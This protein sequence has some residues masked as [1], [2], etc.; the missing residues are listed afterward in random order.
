MAAIDKQRQQPDSDLLDDCRSLCSS[1]AERLGVS[2]VDVSPSR[3]LAQIG[4]AVDRIEAEK[5]AAQRSLSRLHCQLAELDRLSSSLQRALK[6]ARNATELMRTE[7]DQFAAK[8]ERAEAAVERM[9]LSRTWRY[10]E[11]ARKV[12]GWLRKLYR[13]S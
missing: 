12:Y 13:R 1:L 3:L 9:R 2:L 11:P 5:E 8:L 10:T 7:R 4:D 6:E